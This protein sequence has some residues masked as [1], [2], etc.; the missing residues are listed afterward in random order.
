MIKWTL[1]MDATIRRAAKAGRTVEQAARD[2]L[3]FHGVHVSRNGVS[4]RAYRLDISFLST[5]HRQPKTTPVVGKHGPPP[6]SGSVRMAELEDHHCRW[7]YG[8][9][10]M[11]GDYAFCGQPRYASTAYCPAHAARCFTAGYQPQDARQWAEVNR[12]IAK[13]KRVVFG[14]VE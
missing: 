2:I 5:L 6:V 3:L 14:G 1:G 11:G 9:P 4:G 7:V 10:A 13:A 8:E 12:R